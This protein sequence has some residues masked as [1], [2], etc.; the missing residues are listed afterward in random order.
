MAFLKLVKKPEGGYIVES[1]LTTVAQDVYDTL[2]E[3]VVKI[4]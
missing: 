4:K 2:D 3:A 1:E